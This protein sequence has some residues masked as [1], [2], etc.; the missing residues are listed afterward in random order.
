MRYT[1]ILDIS[2]LPEVYENDKAKLLYLHLVLKAGYS[3]KD[4]GAYRTSY[5]RLA[6][7][8]RMTVSS[9]RWNIAQL[10]KAR[11]IVVKLI[12][13]KYGKMMYIYVAQ[14]LDRNGNPKTQ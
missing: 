2:Q 14:K 11:L 4:H 12:K 7:E 9:V 5:N 10:S 1:T 6:S 13:G 3:T 8:T